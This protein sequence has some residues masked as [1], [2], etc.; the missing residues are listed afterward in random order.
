[1]THKDGKDNP[2]T[3]HRIFYS[4]ILSSG[5]SKSIA[6]IFEKYQISLFDF[7][8]VV[9]NDPDSWD[10][11]G[12]SAHDILQLNTIVTLALISN[13][14]FVSPSIIIDSIEFCHNF[15]I[16]LSQKQNRKY[17][18]KCKHL[19]PLIFPTTSKQLSKFCEDIATFVD[20]FEPAPV[21]KKLGKNGLEFCGSEKDDSLDLGSS[22]ASNSSYSHLN[23]P[24]NPSASISTHAT[25][26]SP[27]KTSLRISKRVDRKKKGLK[28]IIKKKTEKDDEKQE[29]DRFD[30][31]PLTEHSKPLIAKNPLKITSKSYTDSDESPF[32]LSDSS[33]K[34]ISTD[35]KLSS[36]SSTTFQDAPGDSSMLVSDTSTNFKDSTSLD[37][38]TIHGIPSSLSNGIEEGNISHQ[39]INSHSLSSSISTK[40][41][42]AKTKYVVSPDTMYSR[43]SFLHLQSSSTTSY[44]LHPN[45]YHTLS[46]V[47][48]VHELSPFSVL[49]L[50]PFMSRALGLSPAHVHA[51]T[52]L[53][54]YC[55]GCGPMKEAE[56]LEERDERE[57]R[58]LFEKAKR[59]QQRER[60]RSIDGVDNSLKRNADG[61]FRSPQFSAHMLGSTAWSA[62]EEKE[63]EEAR[64]EKE[65]IIL[66]PLSIFLSHGHRHPVNDNFVYQAPPQQ[67]QSHFSI[68][69]GS[70]SP[71]TVGPSLILPSHSVAHRSRAY[72][73]YSGG[74][75]SPSTSSPAGSSSHTSIPYN[76]VIP[77]THV[78]CA[79]C[80]YSFDGIL[81]FSS[82]RGQVF[83]AQEKDI[84][85]WGVSGKSGWSIPWHLRDLGSIP[86]MSS[87]SSSDHP[88]HIQSSD[89]G[90]SGKGKTRGRT[91]S[92]RSSSSL[93][94]YV[95]PVPS[96]VVF[97]SSIKDIPEL[98]LDPAPKSVEEECEYEDGE[99]EAL[100]LMERKE[101]EEQ[102]EEGAC[103]TCAKNDSVDHG[104]LGDEQPLAIPS[105]STQSF[106][107]DPI[108]S[109]A[110]M[111]SCIDEIPKLE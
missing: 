10:I 29:D 88:R 103:K 59:R 55:V 14:V 111:D 2:L 109:A 92:R 17:F 12:V 83:R 50:T 69:S 44:T 100:R 15:S 11:L 8:Y 110:T 89:S 61:S 56:M 47:I 67:H 77:T 74:V 4:L 73:Q 49:T 93:S 63:D 36:Q 35:Q 54:L 75:S 62:E 25:I 68:G 94:R 79:F 48:R 28:M 85:S 31:P 41:H 42:L 86:S 81:F 90:A 34:V 32:I 72:G 23:D 37:S 5:L 99:E 20:H 18:N 27:K 106:Q 91:R 39:F 24:S 98:Y 97:L 64:R 46:H 96:E 66:S 95:P 80:K 43:F 30:E 38:D 22:V 13:P 51:V 33:S 45:G 19:P 40:S 21:V 84:K 65:E 70:V 57:R 58:R 108:A 52:I 3:N 107:D 16:K 78:H 53:L 60:E 105:S 1:M 82:E 101:Q 7:L 9:R 76:C 6:S 71:S 104:K 26:L 102:E 87:E